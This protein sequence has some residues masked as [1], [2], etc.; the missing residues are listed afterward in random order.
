MNTINLNDY[1]F[2]DLEKCEENIGKAGKFTKKSKSCKF[3]YA[4]YVDYELH[5][6]TNSHRE[7]IKMCLNSILT[8]GL[9]HSQLINDETIKQQNNYR[10]HSRLLEEVHEE[11]RSE[12][13]LESIIDSKVSNNS[14]KQIIE[15]RIKQ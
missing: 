5:L 13:Y 2:G 11:I 1:Y 7:S 3:C 14:I 15:S 4:F 9:F 6:T 12:E 10:I 8:N